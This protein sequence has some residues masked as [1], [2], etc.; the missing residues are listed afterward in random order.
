MGLAG[1]FAEMH[2]ADGGEPAEVALAVWAFEHGPPKA[3]CAEA[4]RG[5]RFHVM[6]PRELARTCE[7]RVGAAL[8]CM[9]RYDSTGADVAIADTDEATGERVRTHE[10]LHVLFHCHD[11]TGDA[12]YYHRDPIWQHIDQPDSR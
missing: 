8:G 10:L 12:D 3:P 4:A 7:A 11:G 2:A 5:A 1:C 6:Q 9:F